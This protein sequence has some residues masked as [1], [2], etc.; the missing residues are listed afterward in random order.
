TNTCAILKEPSSGRVMTVATNQPG[1]QFYTGN[2]L[3]TAL[4]GRR[5]YGTHAGLC[6]ETQNYPDSVHQA[7]FPSPFLHPGE[8]YHH[9]T[10]HQF[11]V[12][13]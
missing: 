3:S 9:L 10:I 2:S 11:S 6:L 13:T 7:S 4:P 12:E 8:E 5:T 1:V